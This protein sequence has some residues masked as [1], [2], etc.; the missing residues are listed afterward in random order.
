MRE[1]RTHGSK[2]QGLET[3]EATVVDL[4][5]IGKPAWNRSA[6]HLRLAPR[7]PLTLHDEAEFSAYGYAEQYASPDGQPALNIH[8]TK[9]DFWPV[10]INAAG[11]A[12]YVEARVIEGYPALVRYVPEHLVDWL[13]RGERTWVQIYDVDRDLLVRVEGKHRS[14]WASN[15]DGTI[16]VA[17]SILKGGE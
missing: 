14:L 4:G 9:L 6:T 17:L 7:Q 13:N 12:R 11:A 10:Y 2:W 15:I 16:A 5:A 1:N 8:V 3:D